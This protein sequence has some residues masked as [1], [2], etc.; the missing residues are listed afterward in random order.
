MTFHQ[1]ISHQQSTGYWR[2]VVFILKWY[3]RFAVCKSIPHSHRAFLGCLTNLNHAARLPFS[4]QNTWLLS[5]LPGPKPAEKP[6]WALKV[7]YHWR[8]LEEE[9]R[10]PKKTSLWTKTNTWKKLEMPWNLEK[11]TPQKPYYII[12]PSQL[13]LKT[14][15]LTKTCG[16][17]SWKLLASFGGLKALPIAITTRFYGGHQ[18]FQRF[19]ERTAVKHWTLLWHLEKQEKDGK[20]VWVKKLVATWWCFIQKSAVTSWPERREMEFSSQN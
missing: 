2:L 20:G 10:Q 8:S 15:D 6:M 19:C 12:T 14:G 4:N 5:Q 7:L 17:W 9:V 13:A 3:L 18:C 11:N 1:S 16:S